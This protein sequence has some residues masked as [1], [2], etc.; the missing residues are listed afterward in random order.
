ME[1]ATESGKHLAAGRSRRLGDLVDGHVEPISVA[2]SPHPCSSGV[3]QIG[4]VDG[5]QV[6]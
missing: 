4:D 5:E 1:A 6:Q 3:G 2:I